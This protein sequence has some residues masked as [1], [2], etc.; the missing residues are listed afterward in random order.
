MHSPRHRLRRAPRILRDVILVV[1]GAVLALL[2]EEWRDRRTEHRRA[3]VAVESIR[4]ELVENRNRVRRAR[5][6]HLEM[7][8]TLEH[9]VAAKTLPPERIYFGGVFNPAFP[10]STA[11]QAARETG[12]LTTLP[13]DVVLRIAP[14][15]ELQTSYRALADALGQST[16]TDL[17]REGA[18]PVFRDRYANF[19]V[20]ERDFANRE[21]VLDRAYT[22][23]L[24]RLDS[25]AGTS[26]GA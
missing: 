8:D 14:V 13:Y 20:L 16:M 19:I 11:W 26:S 18:L 22:D 3:A 23:A 10:L 2:T 5:A 9:Y 25:L 15:Y 17:E 6:H 7:A 21:M 12:S 1:L 24:A 4:A